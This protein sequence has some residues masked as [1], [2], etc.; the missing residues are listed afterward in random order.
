VVAIVVGLQAVGVVLMSAMLV[1]PAV[2][3]RQ[4]TDRL[5]VMVILSACLGALAGVTGAIIS[6]SVPRL[7]TG[8]MIVLIVSAFVLVSLLFAPNRG[9]VWDWL[10]RQRNRRQMNSEAVLIDLYTLASQHADPQHPHTISALQVMGAQHDIERSLTSLA[11][12]GYVRAASDNQWALTPAGL[13]VA[14]RRAAEL[15]QD[16]NL[17]EV[18]S[19]VQSM[20]AEP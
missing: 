2:A 12:L 13:A 8:P 11:A 6:S 9:L 16:R 19:G 15:A 7:S 20:E 5:S 1:A 3:A 18:S 14:R 4:W 17:G 10:R